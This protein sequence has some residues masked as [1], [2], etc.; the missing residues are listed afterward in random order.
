MIKLGNSGQSLV[1]FVLLIPLMLLVLVIVIDCG[2]IMVEKKELNNVTKMVVDY[3]VSNINEDEVDNSMINL[4]ELNI[5]GATIE[6]NVSDSEV[7]AISEKYVKGIF[8]N[9]IGY[10]GFKIE[11]SYNIYIDEVDNG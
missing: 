5:K 9:I 3:G 6:V 7:S 2:K 8:S 1:L 11:S 10:D 4:F